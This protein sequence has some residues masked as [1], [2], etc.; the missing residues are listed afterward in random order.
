[1]IG[2]SQFENATVA[3]IGSDQRIQ[4]WQRDQRR[5]WCQ[6]TKSCDRLKP[7]WL[8]GHE[9]TV[10]SSLAREQELGHR[11]CQENHGARSTRIEL[12]ITLAMIWLPVEARS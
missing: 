4:V 7:T 5:L 3:K 2:E 6:R 9:R 12:E 10:E 11:R 8:I 1:M